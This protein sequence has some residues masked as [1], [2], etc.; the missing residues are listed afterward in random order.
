MFDVYLYTDTIIQDISYHESHLSF[1]S[2]CFVENRING[3]KLYGTTENGTIRLI[4]SDEHPTLNRDEIFIDSSHMLDVP[5]KVITI[6]GPNT[7]ERILTLCEVF[8]YG[9]LSYISNRLIATFNGKC[10]SLGINL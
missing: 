5:T 10:I 3:F 2:K 7:G 9:I 8:V 1:E 6:A 4:Y